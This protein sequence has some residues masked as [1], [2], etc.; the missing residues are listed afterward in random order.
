MDILENNFDICTIVQGKYAYRAI[1]LFKSF[2]K[3]HFNSNFY[4]L[5]LDEESDKILSQIN[6]DIL[7]II[8]FKNFENESLLKLRNERSI[9]EYC[10]TCKPYFISHIFNFFKDKNKWIFYIDADSCIFGNLSEVIKNISDK[11]VILTP[12]RSNI[13][14]FLNDIKSSGIYN[15][16]F[17]GF[18]NDNDGKIALKWWLKKC[19][20]SCSMNPT[21]QVYGDQL[22][23]NEM[24]NLF[25]FISISNHLGLNAAPWNIT[26]KK[27]I[28]INDVIF[29]ND[30]KL[31]HYHFQGL[32][33]INKNIFDIYK[34]NYKIPNKIKQI[35]YKKYIILLNSIFNKFKFHNSYDTKYS[36]KLFFRKIQKITN[37]FN[38]LILIND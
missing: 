23:L 7:N 28:L 35:I 30:F 22:Y 38:N 37:G 24:P 31:L 19:T 5:S 36:F 29:V 11:S 27:I 20:E 6:S 12:H 8:S 10:W 21:N 1:A 3:F 9:A 16:G 15:A 26:D 14:F 17:I 34:G 33:I 2:Q 32:E 18:K 13:E 4:I 25:D